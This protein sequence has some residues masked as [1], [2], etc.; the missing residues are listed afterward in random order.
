MSGHKPREIHARLPNWFTQDTPH[1]ARYRATD[2]ALAAQRLTTVCREARCPNRGTCFCEGTATLL[3]LGNRCTRSCRFCAIGT[4]DDAASADRRGSPYAD[5]DPDEPSRVAA[6]VHQLG[7]QHVVI[8]SVTRDD[9]PDGGAGHFAE[10]IKTIRR[11][12]PSASIEVLVPDFAGNRLALGTVL[13]ARPDVL[14]HNLETVERVTPR[15]RSMATYA[16]SLGLLSFA[17][18]QTKARP[19]STTAPQTRRPLVKTGLMLGLSETR[20]E[21]L[22]LLTDCAR[23]GVQVVTIGQYLQPAPGSLPVDRYV[24]PEEFVALKRAGERL[25]LLV[26]AGPRVRSSFAAAALFE[27]AIQSTAPGP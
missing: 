9:L 13:S 22:G 26:E 2:A 12:T 14:A 23:A 25:G 20:D 27:R 8:T 15:A 6:A 18:E 1:A 24:P 4:H 10:T 3:I 17:A 16:R 5:P 21:V 11:V 7:L 19:D